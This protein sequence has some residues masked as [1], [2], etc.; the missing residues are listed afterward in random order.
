MRTAMATQI[1]LTTG[2]ELDASTLARLLPWSTLDFIRELPGDGERRLEARRLTRTLDAADDFRFTSE[3]GS[4]QPIAVFAE[5]LPWDSEFFGFGVVRLNA[6]W[7][8]DSEFDP[9]A[10]YRRAVE[11]LIADAR[12]RGMRY[13]F[14]NVDPRNLPLLRALGAAGFAV[15]E[16]RLYYHR[17]LTDY[18]FAER[19]PVRLATEEDVPPLARTAREMVNAFDRFHAD[20]FFETGAVDRLMEEWV[21]ASIV[22]GFADATFVPDAEQPTA[23]C[24]LKYHKE[25]WDAWGVRI[26]Q[27]VLSAVGPEF[28]GWYRKLISEISYHLRD[29]GAAHAYLTTQVTNGA[30][31]RVWET[32]GYRYGRSEHVLRL[33][34]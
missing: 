2:I 7:P 17:S 12:L 5:R 13:V 4:G 27:P 30:V 21:H 18:S 25:H 28:K 11:R 31:I 33:V 32:L 23:F 1:G 19:Y 22:N 10:D 8:T 6:I 20:P 3:S 9:R 29:T 16:T 34:L 26:S 15:I 14:A 24:T